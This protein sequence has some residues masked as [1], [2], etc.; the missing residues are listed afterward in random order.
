[1]IILT[2]QGTV[3]PYTVVRRERV[4]PRPGEILK[5]P[6]Q[7]VGALDVVARARIPQNHQIINVAERL[8]VSPD[9]VDLYM[10]KRPNELVEADEPIAARRAL[11]G[12]RS[13][14]V[15]SP[16]EG[17]VVEVGS[18]V[19]VLEGEPDIIEVKAS[20]PGS[21]VQSLAPWGV[22][23]E[24]DGACAHLAWGHG[25]LGYSELK[26]LNPGE[27]G[28]PNPDT[29]DQMEHR[30][31]IVATT[32]PLNEALLQAASKANV[33]GVIAASMDAALVPL[34]E[35]L[36]LTVG[37]TE[38]FGHLPMSSHVANL[39]RTNIRE[40]ITL[41]PGY[42]DGWRVSRPEIIIPLEK[43]DTEASTPQHGEPL[44]VNHKVRILRGP[45]RGAIGRVAA[46]PERSRQV[47]SGLS[48]PGA[49]IELED[50][51]VTFVPFA[52]LEHLG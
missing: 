29:L 27:D 45:H 22:V 17:R 35:E 36:E 10:L 19:V 32:T 37:L 33:G 40:Q 25:E 52:N 12:L 1:M 30:G 51:Q 15:R 7:S 34:V 41:D 20:V 13:I 31:T 26:I 23:V 46:L 44:A 43:D 6:G 5:N 9:Q 42:I 14:M 11:V 39:L 50:G 49:E 16:V 38:G 3:E 2:Y 4:L 8:N 28:L 47:P 24:V 21:V 48:L 18:G